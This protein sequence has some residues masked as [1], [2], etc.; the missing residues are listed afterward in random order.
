M[1]NKLIV[2][3]SEG[4][5]NQLFMYSHA[6]ALSKKI[7]YKLLLD[8][9]GGYFKNKNKLR[10]HQNFLLDKFNINCSIAPSNLKYDTFL[11]QNLKK[12]FILF[13]NFKSKK[14]F[15]IE[16]SFQLQNNKVAETFIN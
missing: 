3:I 15:L 13:D 11:K 5:G 14:S 10:P 9:T 1:E 7:N 6:F 8:N 16:K 12:L 2:Q 4:L